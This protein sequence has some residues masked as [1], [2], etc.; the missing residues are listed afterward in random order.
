MALNIGK[1][2]RERGVTSIIPRPPHFN[3]ESTKKGS[4]QRMISSY[5]KEWLNLEKKKSRIKM[6]KRKV[7][8]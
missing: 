7:R 6:K 1:I 5:Y 2:E 4:E 8:I 3:L